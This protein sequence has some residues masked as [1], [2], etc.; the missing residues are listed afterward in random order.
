MEK[1]PT[2]YCGGSTRKISDMFPVRK[3]DGTLMPVDWW[4]CSACS[5]KM[6]TYDRNLITEPEYYI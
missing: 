6:F 4:F 1:S 5:G 2:C 3:P